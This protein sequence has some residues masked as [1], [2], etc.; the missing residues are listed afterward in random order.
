MLADTLHLM[1]GR[2]LHWNF[3]SCCIVKHI[4]V[5]DIELRNRVRCAGLGA[6]G[7]SFI[8]KV[9]PAA[10]TRAAGECLSLCS[11]LL[12]GIWAAEGQCQL[13]HTGIPVLPVLR[14]YSSPAFRPVRKRPHS[15][16]RAHLQDSR[17]HR[18]GPQRAKT[19]RR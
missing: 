5:F 16:H 14:R 2:N 4:A 15:G 6:I 12:D 3:D 8:I 13:R 7:T 17:L 9:P 18:A 10:S 19:L 11:D 1:L